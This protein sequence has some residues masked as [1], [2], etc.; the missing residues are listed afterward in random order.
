MFYSRAT[1]FVSPNAA[2][3][4][5]KIVEEIEKLVKSSFARALVVLCM[6]VMSFSVI[7]FEMPSTS[8][9]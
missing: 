3:L 6:C 2:T 5:E 1:L 8:R 4:Y 9:S 7:A